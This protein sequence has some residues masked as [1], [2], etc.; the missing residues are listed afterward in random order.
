M[1]RRPD[2]LTLPS[3]RLP[4]RARRWPGDDRAALVVILDPGELPGPH[5][6]ESWLR[7]LAPQ[8][9]EVVR[10]GALS[11]RVAERAERAGYRCIQELTLL[12]ARAPLVAAAPALRRTSACRHGRA[13]DSELPALAAI[14]RAAFGDLWRLDATMLAD[15]CDATPAHR[16]RVVREEDHRRDHLLARSD[17][18][19]FLI[20]GRSGRHGYLQR[21]AV[22]PAHQR[23]GVAT[24]LVA[25]A[26]T[27]MR[28]WRCERVLVNTHVDNTPALELYHRFAFVELPDR[29]RV[30]EG[31]VP[32]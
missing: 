8:G 15:V 18:V 7:D 24:A 28:R 20:S 9:I 1:L 23:A 25:D 14:D 21:L 5:H 19:G 10:T 30:Y 12:E 11:P 26:L 27:W 16:A 32:T 17:P 13:S 4:V 2:E 22:D 6:F 31:T 29:L 3:R